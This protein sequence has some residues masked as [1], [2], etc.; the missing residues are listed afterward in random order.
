MFHAHRGRLGRAREILAVAERAEPNHRRIVALRQDLAVYATPEGTSSGVRPR[1]SAS[2]LHAKLAMDFSR[3]GRTTEAHEH[4]RAARRLAPT[5]GILAFN[6]AVWCAVTGEPVQGLHL[7][8]HAIGATATDPPA[9]PAQVRLLML[10]ADSF[11]ERNDPVLATRAAGAAVRLAQTTS[12]PNLAGP[13][14]AQLERY[15]QAMSR[16]AARP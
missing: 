2:Q 7:Y 11:H 10:I 3:A 8:F 14:K 6:W 16:A 13:P 15:R 1:P 5:S 12:D 9:L 4:F